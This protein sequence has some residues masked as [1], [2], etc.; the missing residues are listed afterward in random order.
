[1]RIGKTVLAQKYYPSLEN[2]GAWKRLAKVN[3]LLRKDGAH[4]IETKEDYIRATRAEIKQKMQ[5]PRFYKLDPDAPVKFY[6]TYYDPGETFESRYGHVENT[7]G[8]YSK[9]EWFF[10]WKNNFSYPFSEWT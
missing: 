10:D 3:R 8:L 2:E 7:R 9:K 1:M 5:K 6:E 4:D